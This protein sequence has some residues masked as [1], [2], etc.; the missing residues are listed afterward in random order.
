MKNKIRKVLVLIILMILILSIPGSVQANVQSVKNSSTTTGTTGIHTADQFYLLIR[1]MESNTGPMGLS[2]T[3]DSTTGE[4]T[5][6][7]NNIDTHIIKDTEWGAMAM[8][9]DSDYGSK[10]AGSGTWE[11][12]S[13]TG[14]ATGVYE[15]FSGWEVT[16]GIP[17]DNYVESY[18]SASKIRN[19]E[20][21]YKNDYNERNYIGS[22]KDIYYWKNGGGGHSVSYGY[23]ALYAFGGNGAFSTCFSNGNYHYRYCS[24]AITSRAAV[25]CGLRILK[26][27]SIYLK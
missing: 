3:I 14:N 15:I 19:A 7:S 24:N 17:T 22:I 21:K 5:S 9:M 1:Q 27:R 2:A 12:S 20:S 11:I 18:C 13:S 16:S 26:V 8:L 10:Q 4:E 25:T 6:F 23:S